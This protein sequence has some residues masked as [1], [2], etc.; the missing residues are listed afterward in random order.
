MKKLKTMATA[1]M[2]KDEESPKKKS[3]AEGGRRETIV[4]NGK[5]FRQGMALLTE[6]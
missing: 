6:E 3:K 5:A 4:E 1:N 2:D